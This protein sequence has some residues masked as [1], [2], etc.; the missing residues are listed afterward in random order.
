M[1]SCLSEKTDL[2][3]IIRSSLLA[4]RSRNGLAGIKDD[5]LDY[6]RVNAYSLRLL[7]SIE[8]CL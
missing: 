6:S 4:I 2:Q 1:Y 5:L 3:K 8:D 7:R